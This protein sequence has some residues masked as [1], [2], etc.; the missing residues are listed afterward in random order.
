MME[1]VLDFYGWF[2]T[3]VSHL[4]QLKTSAESNPDIDR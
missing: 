2:N 4:I 1:T 3:L